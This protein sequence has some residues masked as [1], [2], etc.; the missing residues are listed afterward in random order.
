MNIELKINEEDLKKLSKMKSEFLEGFYN[1]M[2]LAMKFAESK[3]KRSFGTAGHLGVVTG[4]LR[5][6]IQSGV[7]KF[8]GNVVGWL[9]SETKYSAIHEFGGV[10]KP[11][12]KDYIRFRIQGKWKTVREVVIPQRSFLEK[13]MQ[14]NMDKMVEIIE[15]ET[16]KEMNK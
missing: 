7:D 12:V 16:A 1:G 15:K 8:G 9:S 5:R 10:I 3:S 2:K 14:D 6:S 11:K 4:N 13:P